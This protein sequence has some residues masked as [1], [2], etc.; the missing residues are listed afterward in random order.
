MKKKKKKKK[1]KKNIRKRRSSRR[2]EKLLHVQL[3][4]IHRY[5]NFY[6]LFLNAL[7][8]TK[9]HATLSARD[10][11]S[12]TPKRS[13]Q[14]PRSRLRKIHPIFCFSFFLN[15]LLSLSFNANT[16]FS[17]GFLNPASRPVPN[18]VLKASNIFSLIMVRFNRR[19][20]LSTF[21]SSTTT[22]TYDRFCGNDALILLLLLNN[23]CFLVFV[24]VD[25]SLDDDE[26][27]EAEGFSIAFFDDDDELI[28]LLPTR[29]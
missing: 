17:L 25:D 15:T 26:E 20:A 28:A 6:S 29:T 5:H 27:K 8:L 12:L 10:A 14:N 21:P 2:Y 11:Y 24:V 9:P 1:K 3:H 7:K 23:V 18:L 16:L 13:L 4:Y 22:P 19:I